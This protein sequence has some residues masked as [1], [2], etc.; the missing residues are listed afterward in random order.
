MDVYL[1]VQ[2]LCLLSRIRKFGKIQFPV[3]NRPTFNWKK[4]YK[5]RK[6]REEKE[7]ERE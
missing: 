4:D 1:P 6:R 5:E 7:R 2:P 3:F